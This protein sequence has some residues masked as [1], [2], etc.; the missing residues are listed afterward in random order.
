MWDVTT[1]ATPV[2]AGPGSRCACS[3]AASPKHSDRHGDGG[4][5]VVFRR[6]AA[7]VQQCRQ[8]SMIWG[9]TCQ[10]SYDNV[11][12]ATEPLAPSKCESAERSSRD[13]QRSVR[14][15]PPPP[16]AATMKARTMIAGAA[17]T[18]RGDALSRASKVRQSVQSRDQH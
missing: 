15:R 1:L 4:G 2:R 8:L 3:G 18:E 14:M 11:R 7:A 6:W 9:A 12:A 16:T 17:V 13:F 10:N 5:S